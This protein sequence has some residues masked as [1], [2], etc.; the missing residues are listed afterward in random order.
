MY[1]SIAHRNQP[2]RTRLVGEMLCDVKDEVKEKLGPR[3]LIQTRIVLILVNGTNPAPELL[4]TYFYIESNRLKHT[5]SCQD[6]KVL[7]KG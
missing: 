3:D 7:D 2:A 6:M 5:Q 1:E 4:K